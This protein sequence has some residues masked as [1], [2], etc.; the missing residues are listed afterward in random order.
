MPPFV[1]LS[2][3]IC[4]TYLSCAKTRALSSISPDIHQLNAI[5]T[6]ALPRMAIPAQPPQYLTQR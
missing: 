3:E 5:T 1:N 2:P 4:C 6:N